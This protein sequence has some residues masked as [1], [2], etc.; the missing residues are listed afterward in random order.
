MRVGKD[1]S[2][3][4]FETMAVAINQKFGRPWLLVADW[5]RNQARQMMRGGW[6]EGWG[7]KRGMTIGGKPAS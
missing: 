7:N 1:C 3:S 2:H 4:P 5:S 6:K